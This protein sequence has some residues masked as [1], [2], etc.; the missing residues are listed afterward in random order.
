MIYKQFG[1][2]FRDLT[3]SGERNYIW[4]VKRYFNQISKDEDFK[5]TTIEAEYSNFVNNVFKNVDISLPIDDY[6]DEELR[7]LSSRIEKNS[8]GTINKNTIIHSYAFL[9]YRPCKY[10]FDEFHKEENRLWGSGLSLKDFSCLDNLKVQKRSF[11]RK[12]EEK[13]I[14]YLLLHPETDKGENIGLATSLCLGTRDNE[15][16]GLTYK[17]IIEMTFYPGTYKVRIFDTTELH[18]NKLKAGGKTFDTPRFIVAIAAYADFIVKRMTYLELTLSFPFHD[19]NG[20]FNSVLDLPVCCRGK[21]YSKRCRS[22]DLS[23]AGRIMFRDVLKMRESDVAQMDA[24]RL[25]AASV[26]VEEKSVTT[27]AFRR[28]F[29]TH[30][31]ELGFTRTEMEYIMGHVL[32]DIRY[33][34]ADLTDEHLLILM[35]NKLKDCY[36]NKYYFSKFDKSAIMIDIQN[37]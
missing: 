11:T 28:N 12:E 33:K 24:E 15:C 7:N 4:A 34:R 29:A 6:G 18:S 5:D 8:N 23:T 35:Y 27:Y 3:P 22:D 21:D 31:Y 10:Y 14:D 25:F 32:T 19:E 17:D 9:V 16:T 20:T 13:I 30:C 26:D 2:Q 1:P 37:Y 36:I